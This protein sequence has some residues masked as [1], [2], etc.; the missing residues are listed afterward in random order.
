MSLFLM[1]IVVG[2]RLPRGVCRSWAKAC[3]LS[4]ELH[5]FTFP[6]FI[7]SKSLLKEVISDVFGSRVKEV[8]VWEVE[9]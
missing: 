3:C 2:K 1:A 8:I 4:S 7:D 5:L 9:G 6:C